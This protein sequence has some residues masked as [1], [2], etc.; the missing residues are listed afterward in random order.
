MVNISLTAYSLANHPV[1]SKAPSNAFFVELGPITHVLVTRPRGN[2]SADPL[3]NGNP[4]QIQLRPYESFS[5]EDSIFEALVDNAKNGGDVSF[6]NKLMQ[7]VNLNVVQVTQDNGTPLT[8]KQ[9]LAYT[10][11]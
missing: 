9:I 8:S 7:L 4:F 5:L 11:P 6:I 1:I 2:S 3:R 10:A